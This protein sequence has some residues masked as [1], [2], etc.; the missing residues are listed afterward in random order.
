MRVESSR[1]GFVP[2]KKKKK[3]LQRD[4]YPLPPHD[5]TMRKNYEPGREPTLECDHAGASILDFPASRTIRNFG[6]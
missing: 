1:M 2:H 5:D 3:R 4:P 6:C